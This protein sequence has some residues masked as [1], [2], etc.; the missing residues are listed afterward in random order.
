MNSPHRLRLLL[1][2]TMTIT[3]VAAVTPFNDEHMDLDRAAEIGR[4][5]K[6][7]VKTNLRGEKNGVQ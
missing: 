7:D 3:T 1:L 2:F 4:E 6:N 5:T